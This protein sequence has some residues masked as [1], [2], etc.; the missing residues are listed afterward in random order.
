MISLMVGLVVGFSLG[1]AVHDVVTILEDERG[2][3]ALHRGFGESEKQHERQP[4]DSSVSE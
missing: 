4:G 3:N 1:F 2:A